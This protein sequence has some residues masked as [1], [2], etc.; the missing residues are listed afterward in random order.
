MAIQ[1][2]WLP[3]YYKVIYQDMTGYVLKTYLN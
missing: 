2:I 1:S 3:G